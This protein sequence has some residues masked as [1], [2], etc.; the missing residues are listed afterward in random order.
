MQKRD[1]LT[2]LMIV[3]FVMILICLIG[4]IGEYRDNLTAAERRMDAW[5]LHF[6]ADDYFMMIDATDG[7]AGFYYAITP[8]NHMRIKTDA[9]NGVYDAYFHSGEMFLELRSVDAT[10]EV[11]LTEKQFTWIDE[12][13]K[14]GYPALVYREK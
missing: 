13:Y 7:L 11:P 8:L 14:D 4:G 1:D 3:G 10:I 9:P 2:P 5:E 6:D 12:H